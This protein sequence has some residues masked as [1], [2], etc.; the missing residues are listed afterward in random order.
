M[1]QHF[2]GYQ[3]Y[4]NYHKKHNIDDVLLKYYNLKKNPMGSELSTIMINKKI[5]GF[6]TE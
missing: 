5:N 2:Q 1:L 3:N 6:E 4:Q